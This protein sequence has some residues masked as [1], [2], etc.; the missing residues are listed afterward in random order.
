MAGMRLPLIIQ[1][2]LGQAT[3][4]PYVP[5]LSARFLVWVSFFP[6]ISPYPQARLYGWLPLSNA[7]GIPYGEKQPISIILRLFLALENKAHSM[8]I[9]IFLHHKTK[10]IQCTSAFPCITKQYTHHVHP[11]FLASQNKIHPMYICFSLHHKTKY[12]QCTSLFRALKNN[13]HPMYIPFS[14]H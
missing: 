5:Y 6:A 8:Y 1:P 4:V 3:R 13:I 14:V 12:I 9:G 7:Y 2:A 10:H 11:L